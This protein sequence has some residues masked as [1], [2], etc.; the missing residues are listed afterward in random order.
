MELL[1]LE[2]TMKFILNQIP[3][4][5]YGEQ[6]VRRT[7]FLVCTVNCVQQI[8]I[9]Q[10]HGTHG[11]VY[12]LDP[13]HPARYDASV[14]YT[15]HHC[16]VAEKAHCHG[17][18][19]ESRGYGVLQSSSGARAETSKYFKIPRRPARRRGKLSQGTQILTNTRILQNL[20]N[21]KADKR[22]LVTRAKCTAISHDCTESPQQMAE[23]RYSIQT[24]TQNGH[25]P[26][27]EG[28]EVGHKSAIQAKAPVTHF[29]TPDV[30]WINGV[31]TTSD[32][33]GSYAPQ[34]ISS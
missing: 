12:T 33:S 21:D 13:S 23:M 14:S 18:L 6:A 4:T 10:L 29:Y 34:T 16:P 3:D 31:Y 32:A 30:L 5:Q 28:R 20:R 11:H 22:T 27:C 15:I 7:T 2:R 25:I 8:R 9:R 1:M 17:H 26:H 24:K 19:R